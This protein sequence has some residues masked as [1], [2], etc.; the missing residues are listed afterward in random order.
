M[1]FPPCVV[2]DGSFERA[3]LARKEKLKF[4]C[5]FNKFA[6]TTFVEPVFRGLPKRKGCFSLDLE[7]NYALSCY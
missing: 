1:L 4:N 5:A 3:K 2:L 6:V 7:A